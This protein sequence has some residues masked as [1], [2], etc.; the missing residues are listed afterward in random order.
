MTC[1]ASFSTITLALSPFEGSAMRRRYWRGHLA[2]QYPQGEAHAGT[3]MGLCSS[4]ARS[5]QD[6]HKV[7]SRLEAM[8]V[9]KEQALVRERAADYTKDGREVR[10]LVIPFDST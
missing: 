7:Y 1:K 3:R 5:F 8:K 9:A 10:P 6:T 4:G 2:S